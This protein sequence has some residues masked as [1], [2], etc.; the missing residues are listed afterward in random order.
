MWLAPVLKNRIQI[1]EPIHTPNNVNGNLDVTF[2]TLVTVWAELKNVSEYIQAVRGAQ[3]GR[4]GY[5]HK[6]RVRKVAVAELGFGF[7]TGFDTG[8]KTIKD[9]HTL[10]TD[11]FVFLEE[12]SSVKGRR[13]RI[14][15]TQPDENA[16]EFLQIF[17]T[18]YREEGT[19]Y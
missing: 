11:Y 9:I 3:N 4:F 5:T 8:F 17:A 10:K 7:D 13:F 15:G 16:N 2:N 12:G 1:Q 6:F 19:G 14:E 18:E